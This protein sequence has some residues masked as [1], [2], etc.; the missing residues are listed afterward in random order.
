MFDFPNYPS[1]GM[2]FKPPYGPAYTYTKGVWAGVPGDMAPP[3]QLRSI[4]PRPPFY[5]AVRLTVDPLIDVHLQQIDVYAVTP[6]GSPLNSFTPKYSF[7]VKT[8]P[9]DPFDIVVGKESPSL[10][11]NGDFGSAGTPPPDLWREWSISDGRAVHGADPN[12]FAMMSLDGDNWRSVTVPTMVTP[13]PN[14]VDYSPTLDLFVSAILGGSN[15]ASF[16]SSRDGLTWAMVAGSPVGNFQNICWGKDRFVAVSSTATHPIAVSTDG[17]AWT[18]VAKNAQM[19]TVCWSDFLSQFVAVS[20]TGTQ[21]AW[22]SPDGLVWTPRNSPSDVGWRAVCWSPELKLYVALAF[23]GTGGRLMTSTNGVDWTQ[24]TLPGEL[25]NNLWMA[26]L[27]VRELG[28]FFAVANSG[29]MRLMTSP[30]GLTWTGVT[31]LDAMGLRN[32]AWSPELNRLIAVAS[33][34]TRLMA[35]SNGVN[36][37]TRSNMPGVQA[38][39]GLCYSAY[40]KKFVGVGRTSGAN[41]EACWWVNDVQMPVG[42]IL[43]GAANVVSGV[44][45]LYAANPQRDA[46][47]TLP[48]GV[49]RFRVPTPRAAQWVGFGAD[50]YAAASVDDF[51]AFIEAPGNLSAG[52]W[53]F[54][55]F[56]LNVSGV[57]GP[58]LVVSNVPV[59]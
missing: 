53:D 47:L 23:S 13:Q 20:D 44:V 15:A 18:S 33:S 11:Q 32:L 52:D 40:Q 50:S 37:F 34:G 6:A 26:V 19:W 25:N 56:P 5:G 27:W 51:S 28:K 59:P 9:G 1:E 21:R 12:N 8:L 58:A 48:A 17:V 46:L 22:T 16:M 24:A 43:R 55:C 35:S 49:S 29:T 3:R 39:Y 14:S 36:W 31:T 10:S 38:W 42:T 57:Q 41:P 45:K 30:D 4:T 7:M 2:T 54:Y